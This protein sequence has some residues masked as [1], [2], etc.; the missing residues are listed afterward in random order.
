MHADEMHADELHAPFADEAPEDPF[1]TGDGGNLSKKLEDLRP[2]KFSNSKS[3][4][5]ETRFGNLGCDDSAQFE[6]LCDGQSL[7]DPFADNT[8]DDPHIE[9][10]KGETSDDPKD[11]VPNM[12]PET[13]SVEPEKWTFDVW[14]G[15]RAWDG[16]EG[17]GVACAILSK[18]ES[19]KDPY[20]EESPELPGNS[21]TSKC[22]LT[23]EEY[24]FHEGLQE[25]LRKSFLTSCTGREDEELPSSRTACLS[26]VSQPPSIHL[27]GQENIGAATGSTPNTAA[28]SAVTRNAVQTWTTSMSH[29]W[30]TCAARLISSTVQGLLKT[31]S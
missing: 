22:F 23:E 11:L 20:Y 8:S 9:K 17:C 25:G 14:H 26:T 19:L 18:E 6:E 3:A 31:H 12:P 28:I 29:I 2:A 16:R 5:A 15:R 10:D 4:D 27:Q 21:R 30:T 7:I 1:A 13:I 24:A